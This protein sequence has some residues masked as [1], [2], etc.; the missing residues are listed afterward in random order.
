MQSFS[1]HLNELSE[2]K[3]IEEADLLIE[4]VKRVPVDAKNIRMALNKMDNLKSDIDSLKMI[5]DL[6]TQFKA[7]VLYK[8][9]LANMNDY[10]A[11]RVKISGMILDVMKSCDKILQKA[12]IPEIYDIK[13][14]M[15]SISATVQNL[16]RKNAPDYKGELPSIEAKAR[17]REREYQAI[18]RGKKIKMGPR[19][20]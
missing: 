7:F 14:L 12:S 2:S 17:A 5:S 9:K 11:L 19:P 10:M 16:V 8:P 20:A 18:T 4:A 3:L 6:L 15:A 13:T 1:Q